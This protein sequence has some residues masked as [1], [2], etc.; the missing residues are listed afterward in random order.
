MLPLSFN[1]FMMTFAAPRISRVL[2]STGEIEHRVAKRVVDMSLLASA[3]I[4]HG[5]GTKT[6]RDAA[7]R[8][9]EMHR[10][11]DIHEDD[12]IVVGSEAVVSSLELADQCG[13]R[14]VTDK[15]REAVRRFH[16]QMTQAF[17][18]RKP[19]PPTLP[20][21]RQF[22]S[23]YLDREARFEPQ[24][25][26]LAK[27]VLGYYSMLFP[28]ALRPLLRYAMVAIL[29]PRIARA[30][31]MPVSSL[32]GRWIAIKVIR[33]LGRRDPVADGGPDG[34]A[35]LAASVYPNGWELNALGTHIKAKAA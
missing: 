23:D 32:A 4:G 2:E 10:A 17:G 5:L 22:W 33:L 35:K 34:L 8:V 26:R 21:V 15:E 30:C 9:N 18:S 19:L 12:F 14:P 29:D 11:Y 20:L 28:K 13:W 6:G 24:N 7:R 27:S 31:G 1:S 3:V 25:L 16:S